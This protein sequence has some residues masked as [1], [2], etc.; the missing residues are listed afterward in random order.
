MLN[1]LVKSIAGTREMREHRG[2]RDL[3]DRKAHKDRLVR[4]GN[5][6]FRGCRVPALRTVATLCRMQCHRTR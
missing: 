2:Q 1:A 6:V 5:K 3:L 4:K